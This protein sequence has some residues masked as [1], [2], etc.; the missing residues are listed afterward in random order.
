MKADL[1]ARIDWPANDD[2]WTVDQSNEA[3]ESVQAFHEGGKL[4]FETWGR[5]RVV[6]P[7]GKIYPEVAFQENVWVD[8]ATMQWSARRVFTG[9]TPGEAGIDKKVQFEFTGTRADVARMRRI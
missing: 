3:I 4:T 9:F 5:T 2:N 1:P 6:S 8:L 7:A